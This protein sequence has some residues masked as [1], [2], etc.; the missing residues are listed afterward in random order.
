MGGALARP[1]VGTGPLAR[2][3]ILVALRPL[4]ARATTIVNTLGP[5]IRKRA[6]IHSSTRV[7][8]HSSEHLCGVNSFL[9]SFCAHSVRNVPS[10]KKQ[11]HFPTRSSRALLKHRVWFNILFPHSCYRRAD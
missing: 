2:M 6:G 3:A 9:H 1:M 8:R 7:P 4:V 5:L 11:H 10:H